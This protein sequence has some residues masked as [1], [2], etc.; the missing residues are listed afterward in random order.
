MTIRALEQKDYRFSTHLH[1]C[2]NRP[3]S[4]L[5]R[6]LIYTVLEQRVSFGLTSFRRYIQECDSENVLTDVL[7]D[8]WN[9]VRVKHVHHI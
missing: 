2:L 7:H 1:H 6:S 4:A 8:V 5:N 9:E 3:R